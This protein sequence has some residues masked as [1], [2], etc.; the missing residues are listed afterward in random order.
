MSSIYKERNWA[1]EPTPEEELK[2]HFICAASSLGIMD[3][4]YFCKDL[5]DAM[6]K[7][8]ERKVKENENKM[9]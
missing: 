2:Y 8:E 7:L 1:D 4:C 6:R 9:D 3:R 5:R